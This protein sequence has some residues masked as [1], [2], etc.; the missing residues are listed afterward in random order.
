[1]VS[2]RLLYFVFGHRDGFDAAQKTRY[3]GRVPDEPVSFIIDLHFHKYITRE[4]FAFLKCFLL[5]FIS[6][7]SSVGTNICEMRPATK[8]RDGF[9]QTDL[10]GPHARIS[11]NYIPLIRHFYTSLLLK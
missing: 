1:M 3:T 2:I 5:C 9:V 8:I 11:V 7:T 6:T 4:K 10:R